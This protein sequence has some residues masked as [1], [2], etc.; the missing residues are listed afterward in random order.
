MLFEINRAIPLINK[1][2]FF[3]TWDNKARKNHSGDALEYFDFFH[4][5]SLLKNLQEASLI[6]PELPEIAN[7]YSMCRE[8][9]RDY[10]VEN[11]GKI[12]FK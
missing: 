5:S 4:I 7:A 9:M 12:I 3:F 8:K 2:L 10:Q 6:Y 1:G 11:L